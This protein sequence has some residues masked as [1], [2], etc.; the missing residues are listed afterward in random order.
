MT[1]LDL[2]IRIKQNAHPIVIEYKGELYKWTGTNYKCGVNYITDSL[3]EVDF[4]KKD[5]I[6]ALK[7]EEED[8]GKH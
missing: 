4:G 5:C 1:Y 6:K 3:D 7:Y 2:M 8:N